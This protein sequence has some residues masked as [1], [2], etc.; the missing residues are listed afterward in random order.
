MIEISPKNSIEISTFQILVHGADIIRALPFA[1][2]L[3]SE[4]GAEHGN[5]MT[6]HNREHHA[7]QYN[8]SANLAAVFM[9]QTYIS[10]PDILREIA[11]IIC[12]KKPKK[13]RESAQTLLRRRAEPMATG[14][15]EVI[16]IDDEDDDDEDEALLEQIEAAY[17]FEAVDDVYQ[18]HDYCQVHDFYHHDH[19]Y[20]SRHSDENEMSSD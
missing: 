7:P 20:C 13:L 3:G 2:G 9:R 4:E 18:D 1:P 5:K 8:E 16:T 11:K 19:D 12:R 15:I 14:D 10:T 17:E 6:R